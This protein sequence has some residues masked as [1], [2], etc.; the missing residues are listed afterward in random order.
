MGEN[1]ES[2]SR[3]V[4]LIGGVSVQERPHDRKSN[5]AASHSF[6]MIFHGLCFKSRMSS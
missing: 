4:W 3:V 5:P 6:H 1:I 2:A